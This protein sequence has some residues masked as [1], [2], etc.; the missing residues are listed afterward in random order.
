MTMRQTKINTYA[1][2]LLVTITGAGASMMIVNT[3]T[4]AQANSDAYFSSINSAAN[5][6][7][8]SAPR[9]RLHTK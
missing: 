9:H 2:L 5:G 1:A 4:I 8:V 7:P 6:T 3:A